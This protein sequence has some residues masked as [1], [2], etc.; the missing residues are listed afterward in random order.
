MRIETAVRKLKEALHGLEMVSAVVIYDEILW[1]PP[2]PPSVL[3]S[4]FRLAV[5]AADGCARAVLLVPN[6]A[7]ASNLQQDELDVLVGPNMLW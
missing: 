2:P 4:D 1:Q 3:Q 5:G 7:A 6:P